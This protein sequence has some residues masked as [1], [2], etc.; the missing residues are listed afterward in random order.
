MIPKT[1]V[2]PIL[3]KVEEIIV[4]IIINIENGLDIPP[5]KYN[6]KVIDLFDFEEKYLEIFSRDILKKIKNGEKG[7]TN[8]LP[9][10]I[11]EM[12]IKNKMFGYK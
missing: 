6:N 10:G 11:S 1:K 2:V 5:V 3:K 8:K 7:W 4:G 12:I 9:E